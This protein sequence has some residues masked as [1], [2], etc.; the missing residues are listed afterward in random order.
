[1]A[2]FVAETLGMRPLQ[3]LTEWTCEEL[4]VAFAQYANRNAKENY[5]TMT[6]KERAKKKMTR[7]DRW[8]MPFVTQKQMDEMATKAQ[9]DQKHMDESA[10]IANAM[11]G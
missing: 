11:F 5:D 1:M 9:E 7:I 6:R 10:L 8:A 2:Y 3:I 4:L